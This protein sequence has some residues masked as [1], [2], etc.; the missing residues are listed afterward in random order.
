MSIDLSHINKSMIKK[1]VC[2]HSHCLILF[3]DGELYGFGENINGQLGL[4]IGKDSNYVSEIKK[5]KIDSSAVPNYK[6]VDIACGDMYSLVLVNSKNNNFL[7]KFGLCKED[8]Y[9]DR[10]EDLKT[11]VRDI[12]LN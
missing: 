9:S 5:L 1:I 10:Y 6:I 8:I 3:S 2:G 4:P 7:V 11:V 12:R